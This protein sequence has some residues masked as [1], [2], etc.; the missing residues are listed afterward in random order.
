M[1]RATYGGIKTKEGLRR[2]QTIM[3]RN[4]IS[5]VKA[6]RIRWLR[7]VERLGGRRMTNL[8]LRRKSIDNKR[9]VSQ[10]TDE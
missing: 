5:V 4:I 8:K 3:W 10:E 7:H 9:T 1:L 6:Q 2:K